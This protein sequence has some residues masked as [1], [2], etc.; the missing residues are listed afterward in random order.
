MNECVRGPRWVRHVDSERLTQTGSVDTDGGR[1]EPGRRHGGGVW[2]W[3][4]EVQTKGR[5]AGQNVAQSHG[6]RHGGAVQAAGEARSH[7][8]HSQRTERVTGSSAGSSRASCSTL[9]VIW[10]PS[11]WLEGTTA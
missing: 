8:K 10:T 7:G 5:W 3:P 11:T 2:M 1:V 9:Q 4:G 6:G